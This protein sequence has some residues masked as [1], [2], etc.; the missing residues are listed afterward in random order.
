MCFDKYTF[1]DRRSFKKKKINSRQLWDSS[2]CPSPNTSFVPTSVISEGLTPPL[3]AWEAEHPSL[4]LQ[5]STALQSKGLVTGRDELKQASV[6]FC[7]CNYLLFLK[8]GS[9]VFQWWIF[10]LATAASKILSSLLKPPSIHYVDWQCVGY[11]VALLAFPVQA[12]GQGTSSIVGTTGGRDGACP[13]PE[14]IQKER[15]PAR[16][17]VLRAGEGYRYAYSSMDFDNA[18]TKI[19]LCCAFI[20][21][22]TYCSRVSAATCTAHLLHMKLRT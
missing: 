20:Y 1:S 15:G 14:P 10:W 22:G 19:L 3:W 21:W 13:G 9:K 4:I 12:P 6:Q 11:P 18:Q 17:L 5:R 16:H 7:N 8:N 2:V